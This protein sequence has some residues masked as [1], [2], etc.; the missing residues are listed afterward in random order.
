MEEDKN[1]GIS[2]SLFACY[3]Y[4]DAWLFFVNKN[5][6]K[7]HRDPLP[8]LSFFGALTIVTD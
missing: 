5:T 7:E 4:T 3:Y 6:Q 1:N 8:C 2:Y